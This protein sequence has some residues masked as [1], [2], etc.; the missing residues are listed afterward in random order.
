MEWTRFRSDKFGSAWKFQNYSGRSKFSCKRVRNLKCE[1]SYSFGCNWAA[2]SDASDET[3]ATNFGALINCFSVRD[4]QQVLPVF[5]PNFLT[6]NWVRPVR[7]KLSSAQKTSFFS[8]VCRNGI[9]EEGTRQKQTLIMM[10]AS[11]KKEE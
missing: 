9:M 2:K 6:L 10:S 3:G 1:F 8:G 11:S 4:N 5:G 7:P